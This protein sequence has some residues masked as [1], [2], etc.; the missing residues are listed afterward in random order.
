MIPL[1]LLSFICGPCHSGFARETFDGTEH[2]IGPNFGR[3]TLL[4][5]TTINS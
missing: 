4:E 5:I 2:E 3:P 1:I